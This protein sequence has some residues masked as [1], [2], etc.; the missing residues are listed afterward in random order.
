MDK[1]IKSPIAY[2]LF[3]GAM[4]VC[5]VIYLPKSRMK[6]KEVEAYWCFNLHAFLTAVIGAPSFM[7]SMWSSLLPHAIVPPIG[8][9]HSCNVDN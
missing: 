5:D 4:Q 7:Y 9:I 1:F 2:F 6:I 8:K 3:F